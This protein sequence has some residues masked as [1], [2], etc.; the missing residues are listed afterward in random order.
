MKQ[1]EKNQKYKNKN[2][3]KTTKR[4]MGKKERKPTIYDKNKVFF[5]KQLA[6]S[7]PFQ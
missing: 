1:E 2:K 6:D 7:V 5:L 3:T 4:G